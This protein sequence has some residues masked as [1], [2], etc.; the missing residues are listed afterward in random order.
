[1]KQEPARVPGRGN[2]KLLVSSLP[3]SDIPGQS[4]LFLEYLCDPVSLRRYYPN[5]VA[6]P[7]DVE[8]FV[9]QVLAN[10]QSDRQV[11]SAALLSL[12]TDLGAG[13]ATLT[14]IRRLA[15][16]D[17]VAVVTGQQAGLFTG[18][19]YTIYKALSAITMA[20]RLSESGIKAVPVFWIATEDHDFD[21]VSEAFFSGRNGETFRAVYRPKGYVENSAVGRVKID[22]TIAKVIDEVFAGS[23]DTEFVKETQ[24]MMSLCWGKSSTFGEAFGKTLISLLG[25]F[26]LIVIDPLDAEIKRLAAPLYKQAVDRAAEIVDAVV[27][28]SRELEA[29]GYHA[30]VVVEKEHFPLFWHNDAGQRLALRRVRDGVYRAKGDDREFTLD[31]LSRLAADQPERFSPGVMLRPVVQDFLLP[32]VCYFGGAAEVAYFAQNSEVY[33]ILERPV[34]P[35][36]HRQS[37]TVLEPKQRRIMDKLDLSIPALFAGREKVLLGISENGPAGNTPKLFGDV[38]EKISTELDRLDGRLSEIDTT[39]AANLA[40]RRRKIVY[41]IGALLKKTL[42]A[43]AR[44]DSTTMQRIDTLFSALL[45]NGQLQERSINVFTFLNKFGLSF[46]EWLYQAVDLDGKDHRVIDV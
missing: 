38:E 32:T 29:A 22:D 16:A 13:E 10:Y 45:P 41:H 36:L 4:R 44:Q 39:L 17:T 19:L 15:E 2:A 35:I 31:E 12:N 43:E 42:L 18:P 14:N 27:E 28:R 1:L 26:G 7:G 33:R 11:L 30:Q 40:T 21:E 37:F 5:A 9:P 3:F 23:P 25:K 24:E 6:S 20:E 8:A 46:I 34:T